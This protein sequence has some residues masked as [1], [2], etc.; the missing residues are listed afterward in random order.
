MQGMLDIYNLAVKLKL[1][2]ITLKIEPE[3]NNYYGKLFF[4][5]IIFIC[6]F[7]DPGLLAGFLYPDRNYSG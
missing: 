1:N 2:S 5:K 4:H 3:I 7:S 6:G